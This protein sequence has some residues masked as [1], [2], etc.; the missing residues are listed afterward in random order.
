MSVPLVELRS[1]EAMRETPDEL[2]ELQALLDDSIER[3]SDFLRSSF[4]MPEHSLSAGHLTTHLQ[5]ALTVALG[6]VTARGEPRVA[7][8]SALFLHASFYVPTVAEA[9]RARHLAQR[10]GASLTYFEGTD[11]A[12]IA[13][14]HATT[15]DA[16]HADFAELDAAQ[17]QC[18][19]Q[20]VREW[21]GHGVYLQLKPASVYTF[22][23]EP[24]RYP[25]TVV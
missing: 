2:Q 14:G 11:L 24:D 4:E 25:T 23:R 6:T 19:N 7:P 17:V 16:D 10:P 9:A 13:H 8:I 5:G 3:A 12:V 21:H 20:S 15:I 1:S 22:A 18:G